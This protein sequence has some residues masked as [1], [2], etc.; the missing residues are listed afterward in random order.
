[1]QVPDLS[2]RRQLQVVVLGSI[3]TAAEFYDFALSG[4]AAALVWPSVFFPTSSPAAS[5]ALSFGSFGVALLF[6]PL[7]AILFGHFGDKVGR[8]G[9]LI[10]TLIAMGLGSLGI[11]LTPSFAAVGL[12]APVLV[13]ALRSAQGF[14]YG[15]EWPGAVTWMSESS[16][17][18]TGRGFRTSWVILAQSVGT[19]LAVA[20]FSLLSSALPHSEFVQSG[21]RWL[22]VLGAVAVVIGAV[23]RHSFVSD[24]LFQDAKALGKIR[25]APSLEV[26]KAQG[27]KI[28]GL[29]LV[30][31][32]V[33]TSLVLFTGTF[34]ILYL[35]RL[36]GHALSFPTV[37]LL[38]ALAY[39]LAIPVAPLAGWLADRLGRKP[40][41]V[42]GNVI[43][44]AAVAAA[45]PL[46]NTGV[47][48]LMGLA[49]ALVACAGTVVSAVLPSLLSESFPTQY[50][51]SGVG[52]AYNLGPVMSGIVSTFIVPFLIATKGGPIG[53]APFIVGLALAIGLVS[54]VS[55]S[56]V[57]ETLG[58]DM[59]SA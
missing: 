3:G 37:T 16:A 54:L 13:V 30:Y 46:M 48:A 59:R 53:S 14:G 41:A 50:R 6:Q 20:S 35:T 39:A 43:S 11:A 17:S 33:I 23:V 38:S 44:L 1:M 25:R 21:W 49:L 24:P 28:F 7:G 34:A 52:L 55:A 32:S 9:P 27:R 18:P 12:I 56:R 19:V 10:G 2:G 4:L 31:T 29:A 45:L 15:G 5:A 8:K 47:V 22:F 51:Y 58:A 26:I 57:K 42:W 40:V 36:P